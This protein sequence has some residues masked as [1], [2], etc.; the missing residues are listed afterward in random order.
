VTIDVIGDCEPDLFEVIFALKPPGL[1]PRCLDGREQQ[2]DQNAYDRDDNEQLNECE[3]AVT[4]SSRHGSLPNRT[5]FTAFSASMNVVLQAIA[6]YDIFRW[7]AIE[8][9][10]W[11]S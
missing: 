10:N 5:E 3:P 8:W 4:H 2:P 11:R 6:V 9:H 7:V 1:S